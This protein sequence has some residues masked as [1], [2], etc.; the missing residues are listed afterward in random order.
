LKAVSNDLNSHV[1]EHYSGFMPSD[2]DN[3]IAEGEGTKHTIFS[4]YKAAVSLCR[5]S[6]SSCMAQM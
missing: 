1:I 4:A 5:S 2:L 3:F 6:V